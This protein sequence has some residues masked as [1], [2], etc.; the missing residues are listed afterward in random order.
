MMQECPDEVYG[1]KEGYIVTDTHLQ[2]AEEIVTKQLIL[3]GLRA[4]AEIRK[5]FLCSLTCH[6]AQ[7]KMQCD[8]NYT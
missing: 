1:L 6:Q 5:N 2:R 3:G 8:K 4:A 7:T